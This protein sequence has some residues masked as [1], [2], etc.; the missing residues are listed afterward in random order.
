MY[1]MF[2]TY[3]MSKQEILQDHVV[4]IEK[5]T[6][7][8]R[9]IQISVESSRISLAWLA[10]P[11]AKIQNQKITSSIMTNRS[12]NN[13]FAQRGRVGQCR[14]PASP[15]P[16][17]PPP[18]APCAAPCAATGASSNACLAAASTGCSTC[19]GAFAGCARS[20]FLAHCKISALFLNKF[21]Q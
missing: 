21:L 10:P 20:A 14:P 5:K 11:G 6:K 17:P 13:S 4:L 18:G 19:S 9:N 15:G 8:R 12:N 2:T 1:N 3:T 7:Y 16:S